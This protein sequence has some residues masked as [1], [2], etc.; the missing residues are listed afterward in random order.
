M[1]WL[2]R[3][4]Y[5][6][7]GFD[8]LH[9]SI[10][11]E[12]VLP[13]APVIIT[14]DDGFR[15]ATEYASAILD[16]HG[17]TATFFLVAGLVGQT[18]R[19]MVPTPG[20]D[21]PLA[22]WPKIRQLADAGFECGAHS[23]THPKLAGLTDQACRREL[24]E[25]REILE[26]ALQRSVVH[27]A[28]PYGSVDARVRQL[29]VHAGYHTGCSVN[30]GVA[31]VRDDLMMLRR[32]PVTGQDSLIDFAWRLRRGHSLR[33]AYRN[34]RHRRRNDNPARKLQVTE[35]PRLSVVVPTYQ[36][37]ALLARLLRALE[38]QT[39]APSHFE[40]II[41]VDGSTD[42]TADW[43]SD[44]RPAYKLTWK[45]Q[46]N[47]GRA[48]ACNRGLALARGS[49]VVLLDDD[50]EPSRR[51][52]Q[53]HLDAHSCRT[54]LGV[55]GAAP[56]EGGPGLPAVG[57]YMARKFNRHLESLAAPGRQFG[58]RDFY[59]GNFS[60]RRDVIAEVGYFDEEFTT[61]GNEDLELSCRLKAAGVQI[62]FN[63]QAV[64]HQRYTKDVAAVV[65]DNIAKGGTAVLLAS[66]HPAAITELKLT[67]H[68]R[69]PRW[70]RLIIDVMLALTRGWAAMPDRVVATMEVVDRFRLPGRDA[71]FALA[72]DYFF[73]LGAGAA[74]RRADAAVRK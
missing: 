61:Y 26:S 59:S 53:A 6:A 34:W 42:A 70:R 23:L 12:A 56:V 65:R 15:D 32:V 74:R 67:P 24:V 4:G 62:V 43:L 17:F 49:V 20:V 28:Y 41:I 50:M 8:T 3:A 7:I 69:G 40:V 38:R 45:W 14:F 68:N 63:A 22:S 57:E 31:S 5:T 72:A 58:L 27:L 1:S 2:R 73:M 13:R 66:K 35:L 60:V 36:R 51:L 37:S 30:I 9:K 55:V 54:R 47:A 16:R 11:G 19:W 44:F 33:E 25:S 46:P 39:L 64:A 29:A 10:T 48:T 71:T 21:L 18:S 52:L